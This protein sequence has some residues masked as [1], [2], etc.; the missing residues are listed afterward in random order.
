MTINRLNKRATNIYEQLKRLRAE[1]KK[2]WGILVRL[3]EGIKHEYGHSDSDRYNRVL[4]N[5][6]K[7]I[8]EALK[9]KK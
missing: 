5:W 2:L 4:L 3:N 8:G 6:N 7:I 1:N 9:D